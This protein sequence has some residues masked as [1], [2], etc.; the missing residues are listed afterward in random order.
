MKDIFVLYA[1]E[2]KKAVKKYVSKL[3]ASGYSCW[4]SAR[5]LDGDKNNLDAHTEAMQD[6]KIVIAFI[7]SFSN[8]SEL[9]THQFDFAEQNEKPIIPIKLNELEKKI[10]TTSFFNTYDWIDT[11]EDSFEECYEI[12]IEF[13]E[14]LA[15]ESG[16]KRQKKSVNSSVSNTNQTKYYLASAG[17]AII[18]IVFAYFTFFS[19]KGDATPEGM[20]VGTWQM[21]DYGD[22]LSRT[23]EQLATYK[24]DVQGLLNMILTVNSDKTY[25]RGMGE[26]F[27]SGTWRLSSDN[28]QFITSPTG[29]TEST[30]LIDQVLEDKLI[31]T[32]NERNIET[33][34]IIITTLTFDKL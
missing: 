8:K 19:D 18:S 27:E 22:N 30:L 25:T 24:Q 26:K 34:T 14:E 3:E 32:I 13:I 4:I 10:T 28:K 5:D 29:G 11:I 15:N 33:N 2:D 21:V 1:P 6:A 23:V 9:L 20:I 12:L 16:I 17:I 7:S 31:F